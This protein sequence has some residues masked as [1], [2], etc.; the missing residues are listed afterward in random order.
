[1]L[2]IDLPTVLQR[3]GL[4]VETM[5][6]YK[7]NHHGQMTAVKSILL[8]HTAGPK[9]GELPSLNVVRNG[10][11][12][13][14]GPLA[15]LMLGRSGKWYVISAGLCYHA[16]ATFTQYQSNIYS[17]GIEAEATGRDP[18][19]IQ[20]YNSY[21]TGV[22]A[23]CDYYKLPISAIF[24]HKEAAKPL[25]RKVDPNFDC[26]IF[27]Q[28]VAKFKSEPTPVRKPEPM[29]IPWSV[30]PGKGA[31]QFIIPTGKASI[32]TGRSWFNAIVN[33]PAPGK[34][35]LWCQGDTRGLWDTGNQLITI[36]FK[37]G[38]SERFNRELHE[39]TTRINVYY[40]FPNGGEFL[41]E[42]QGK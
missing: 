18:W 28:Q 33:G 1:M 38:L 6:D 17:I 2:L 9:T 25:G 42:A 36:N 14:P 37:D 20:Q 23:L 39:E 5:P 3:A 29:F 7:T 26:N 22:R 27:R 35:R 13:L 11:S 4:V 10:R 32:L 40:E 34:L 16:G 12:D 15:Q 31:K 41:V 8:H 19:P 30:P 24:G 21:V